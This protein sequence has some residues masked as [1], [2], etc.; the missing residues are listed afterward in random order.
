MWRLIPKLPT[1]LLLAIVALWSVSALRDRARHEVVRIG[2]TSSPIPL[3][4][5]A[6]GVW[7]LAWPL[8]PQTKGSPVLSAYGLPYT[9]RGDRSPVE[10]MLRVEPRDALEL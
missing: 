1:V 9:R 10:L 7:D 3:V 2:L 4:R 5:D 6:R 8:W